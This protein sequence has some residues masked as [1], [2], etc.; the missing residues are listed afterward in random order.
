[1]PVG[2]PKLSKASDEFRSLISKLLIKNPEQRFNTA[3]VV[4][5]HEF[6]K[7]VDWNKVKAREAEP[8]LLP[9]N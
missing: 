4:M 3:E 8:L 2:L 1:M 6:F 9:L 5:K 7:E